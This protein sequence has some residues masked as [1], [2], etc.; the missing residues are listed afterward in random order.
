MNEQMKILKLLEEGK[1]NAEEAARLLEAIGESEPHRRR[2]FFGKN[3]ESIPTIISSIFDASFKNHAT[4][5]KIKVSP[6]KKIE[7]K[8]LGGDINLYGAEVSEI[9]V[10]KDGCAKI[11]EQ[12]DLLRMK[13]ISGDIKIIVPLNTDIEIRSISGNVTLNNLNSKVWM[14][15]VSGDIEGRGLEGS[16]SGEFVSGDV[17]LEYGRVEQI[18]IYSRTGD[19][20]LKLDEGVESEI[21]IS[22]VS[23][24]LNCDL[25]LT[26]VI[27][28]HNYL[29]GIL[30]APKSKILLKSNHGDITVEKKQK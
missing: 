29:K 23:G 11:E 13:T 12:P 18:T 24:D 2:G 28:K 17:D 6:K 30:N 4:E 21:E 26:D 19:I 22:T 16:F 15:S 14:S 25:P 8:G 3:F 1:I 27:K 20:T 5:E 10:E 9:S 7:L